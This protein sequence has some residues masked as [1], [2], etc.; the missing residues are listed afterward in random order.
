MQGKGV[1]CHLTSLPEV[2]LDGALQFL[3]WLKA[4]GFDAWQ[5][6]P[7][8]P[9]DKH[10]SPYAS[11]S[12]F[13]AWP[14]LMQK[15]SFKPIPDAEEWLDD[16]ALYAAIKDDH[17][18]RPWFEWPTP[19]RDRH[20]LAL[21]NYEDAAQTHREQQQCFDAAWSVL[22]EEATAR[23]IT[24]IGDVPIF[25]AHDSADVWAHRELFQL[26]AAGMPLYVAGVP[27]DYF[28]EDGQKWGTVLYDWNAHERQG[29]RWWI[30]RMKRMYRLFDVV[31]IDH[32][33]G[34]HSNWAVPA[35]D[36]DARRGFW[37]D[38]PKDALLRALV[39]LAP[40][41][42]HIL[43]EDLGIIPDEVIELRRRH[44]LPG[45]AV[46]QFGFDGGSEENPHHPST[47]HDDQVVYTGTHDNNTTVGWWA[48]LDEGTRRK[49]RIL[50]KPDEAPVEG[51]M[52]LALQSAAPLAMFPLQDLLRLD[53]RSRMNTPGTSENN[54]AWS[55]EWS[56]LE[57]VK[58]HGP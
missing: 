49:V 12:A 27:P 19:L 37:Q 4:N 17:D 40:S 56:D 11:P 33:R 41:P 1:L 52:R 34:F 39:P 47:I 10:G 36:D 26:D 32:F 48:E 51:M 44:G 24:L 43:A 13:A 29:W 15:A 55:F 28:S 25:I 5:M 54:W 38:G 9:P 22:T 7:L 30:A 8:T 53:G 42:G 14:K 31:R 20:P 18:G 23:N 6:L 45:M 46:M 2:S 35:D 3:D 21:E 58:K 16:W 50:L 57:G